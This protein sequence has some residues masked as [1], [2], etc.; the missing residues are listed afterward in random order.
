MQENNLLA[1]REPAGR[2]ALRR[3]KGGVQPQA[4]TQSMAWIQV[5][6][7]HIAAWH[8]SGVEAWREQ[9]VGPGD[10]DALTRTYAELGV[11]EHL[12]EAVVVAIRKTREPFALLL[13]LLWLVAAGSESELPDPPVPP[14]SLINGVPLYALDKHTRLERAALGPTRIR[15]S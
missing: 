9:R 4:E 3:T 8:S 14:S 11:L 13:P 5:V 10:L 15:R 1:R 7:P 6:K 2:R 12:L